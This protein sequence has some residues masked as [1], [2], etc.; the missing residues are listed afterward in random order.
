MINISIDD[1]SPH[2]FSSVK[3]LENCQKLIDEFKDIKIS[4]FIPISYWRTIGNT[5][6]KI[7]LSIDM[8]PDFC[9]VL[10][11]LSPKNYELGYH[12]YH[13]GI[14]MKSNNDEF[15]D[16]NTDQANKL[17]DA[18][19][20]TVTKAGLSSHFK[21]IFRPPAWRMSP[22]A[23]KVARERGIKLLALSRDDYAMETYKGEQ[24]QQN[25]VVYFDCAPPIKDL[26]KLDINEIV[27]H[28]CEWDRNYLSNEKVD[29]LI[30]FLNT[31]DN[32]K[33]CFMME[34]LNG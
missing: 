4:L 33:F 16:I 24:D 12:G 34:M 11:N 23:I 30:N 19:F 28:A 18:M 13:H 27:Y 29:E 22:A 10:K 20:D 6:T 7:P 25:D 17:F 31:Y 14:P 8:F 1:V 15:K 21:P 9:E 32:R 5:A 2:P 26:E 3:V